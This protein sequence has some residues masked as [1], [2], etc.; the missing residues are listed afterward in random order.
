MRAVENV[1]VSYTKFMLVPC[2]RIRRW[3]RAAARERERRAAPE[4][5][6]ALAA[7]ASSFHL[8]CTAG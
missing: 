6:A 8:A 2:L 4:H 5:G 1:A 7:C 3:G